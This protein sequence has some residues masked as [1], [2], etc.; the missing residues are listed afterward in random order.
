MSLHEQMDVIRDINQA[1]IAEVESGL[2]EELDLKLKDRQQAFESLF[3]G[4]IPL[5]W[6][7]RVATLIQDTLNADKGLVAAIEQCKQALLQESSQLS[8]GRQA[9]DAYT[10]G[11]LNSAD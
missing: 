3:S 10:S 8:L 5:E 11:R 9:L 2:W 4:E 7:P 1:L 6:V